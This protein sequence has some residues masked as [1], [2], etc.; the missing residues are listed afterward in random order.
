MPGKK[1]TYG[2]TTQSAPTPDSSPALNAKDTKHVQEVLGTLLF[3]VR[4]VDFT[5][6]TAIGTLA[7]QQQANGTTATLDALTHQ[8]LNYCATHPDAIVRYHASDMILHVES[9]ASYLTAPRAGL[10]AA[11]YQQY[12]SSRPL[13]P[14]KPT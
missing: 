11:G 1:P 8:L 3:Y 10:R 5:I 7:S 12:L 6:L 2:A 13:D 9:D 14:I 4:A